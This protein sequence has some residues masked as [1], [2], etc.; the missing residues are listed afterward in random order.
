MSSFGCASSQELAGFGDRRQSRELC[1]LPPPSLSPELPPPPLP[2]HGRARE[3]WGLAGSHPAIAPSW[4]RAQTPTAKRFGRLDAHAGTSQGGAGCPQPPTDGV[5]PSLV[6]ALGPTE[7]PALTRS[8]CHH[9]GPHHTEPRT[10]RTAP[11]RGTSPQAA[12]VTGLAQAPAHPSGFW[13]GQGEVTSFVVAEGCQQHP[14]MPGSAGAPAP[15]PLITDF[16]C[17][18]ASGFPSFPPQP[19]P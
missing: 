5:F 16:V 14:P 6:F 4:V 19:S 10:P 15:A 13:Q 8:R 3:G 9:P 1:A 7:L 11:C 2:G 18:L 17:S 12:G